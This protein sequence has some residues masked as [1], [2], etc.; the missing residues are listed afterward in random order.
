MF[1]KKYCNPIIL[2]LLLMAISFMNCDG[3]HRK[4][5]SNVDVLAESNLLNT[6]SS[7]LNSVPNQPVTIETD[8]ILS[9]GFR[10]KLDYYSKENYIE[11]Y[12]NQTH[13]FNFEAQLTV[14]L[15][16]ENINNSVINKQLFKDFE[17]T[18][19]WDKAI[20]QFVW[21][22]HEAASEGS[23][24]LNTSFRI[25]ETE[26]FKDYTIIINDKGVIQIKPRLLL[27]KTI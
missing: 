16:N 8:T 7:Q 13:Y 3:R 1:K 26:I 9:N 25:P 12:S 24:C 17:T 15:N 11:L 23:I 18:S 2:L 20:M 21:I 19:F 4:H 6:F 10:V 5:K 14:L 22:D 27:A